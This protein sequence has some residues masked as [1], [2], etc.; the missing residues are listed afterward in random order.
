MT[1]RSEELTESREPASTDD[2]LEETERLLSGSGGAGQADDHAA[3]DS[4]EPSDSRAASAR[5][6]SDA[7]P[8]ATATR[9]G[10][11]LG[12]FRPSVSTGE[13]FSPKAFLAF[14]L[15]LGAG[16][17]AGNTVIPLVGVG[18]LIGAFGVAFL[19]GVATSKR[20]YLELSTAGAVAGGVTSLLTTDMMVM[21]AVSLE[22]PLLI[23]AAVGLVA[24]LAGYY[25]GR[26]LRNGLF[27]EIE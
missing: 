6:A 18:S 25:F 19:A 23:G 24:S 22:M 16:L 5:P 21:L 3:G 14:V 13:L 11:R 2:L 26:D 4:L 10:S 12:R 20:R 27:R 15:V 1:D 8:D 7:E 9:S 17:L